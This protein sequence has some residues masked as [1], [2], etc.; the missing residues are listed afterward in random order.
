[1]ENT[2]VKSGMVKPAK[3]AAEGLNELFE[4]SLQDIYWAEKALMKALPKMEKNATSPKLKNG[5]STHLSETE[6]QVIRL[7]EVFGLLGKKAQAK[8][9]DAM[10]GL[11]KEA[12][13]MVEET[14]VGA[15]R[16]AAIIAACQK[17]EHYEI[18]TY[19]T[20]ISF[21]NLLGHRDASK[22][23]AKTL[24]EEKSADAKLSVLAESEINLEA[25]H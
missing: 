12:D 25:A 14:E 7:E 17:V 13:G 2:Q 6:E 8:K 1:M 10:E 21:A 18:A 5:I 22:L 3:G 4:A 9:C 16:D 20:L 19:G 23:L 11:L 15:V 24:Q